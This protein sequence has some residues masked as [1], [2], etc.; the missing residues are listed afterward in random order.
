MNEHNR[1]VFCVA[2]L[3]IMELHVVT[4]NVKGVVSEFFDHCEHDVG[5][6]SKRGL[7]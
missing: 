5:E 1:R 3:H 6:V 4:G 7:F 2:G